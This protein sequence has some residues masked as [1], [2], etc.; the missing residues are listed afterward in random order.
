MF[1]KISILTF[2][3]VLVNF[4]S[5][6]SIEIPNASSQQSWNAKIGSLNHFTPL[7]E[8]HKDASSWL[9]DVDLV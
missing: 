5:Q 9:V 2:L 7:G 8:H 4:V 1:Y 6:N 3:T